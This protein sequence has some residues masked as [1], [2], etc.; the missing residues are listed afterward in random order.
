MADLRTSKMT[1]WLDKKLIWG[2]RK[3]VILILSMIFIAVF[4]VLT[5]AIFAISSTGLQ[6]AD[7]QH[8]ANAAFADAESGLEVIKYW[9]TP[10]RVPKPTTGTSDFLTNFISSLNNE[11]TNNS[12]SSL[13]IDSTGSIPPV[14]LDAT[15]NHSFSAEMEMN[16]TDPYL[17]LLA[18]SGK[19]GQFKQT[20]QVD[21]RIKQY[22]FPIFDYGLATKGPIL[23]D[24]NPT[25]IGANDNNEADVYIESLSDPLALHVTGNTSFDGDISVGNA[26]GNVSFDGDVLIAGDHNQTA[27]DNHVTIGADPVEFPVPDTEYFRQYATGPVIDSSTDTTK[28]MTLSNALVKAGTDPNFTQSV[29]INGILFIEAPNHVIFDRNVALQGII[30][31]NGDVN[32]VNSSILVNGNFA[33]STYPADSLYDA[34]R[35]ETGSS[36]LAPGFS[37]EMAGNFASLGGVMAV[38][39]FTLSGNA[40]ALVRGSIINYS[41]DPTVILG[42]ASLTYDLSG[43][44]D[45]PAGFDNYRILEYTPSS[46]SMIH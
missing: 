35:S 42:N 41:Q 23:L 33:S 8:K 27:I 3:G 29:T 20:I 37:V 31:G 25:M 38:S 40:N 9:L 4:S 18:V 34:I 14:L 21:F 6:M 16:P 24:G 10:L 36:L 26:T 1:Y 15:A 5:V 13:V 39:G 46:W 19:Y 22:I 17:F 7:S 45:V 28:G 11:W 43:Q 44:P 12:V 32:N 30:V 2:N